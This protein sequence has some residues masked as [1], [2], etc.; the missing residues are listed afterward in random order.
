MMADDSKR[1]V[2]NSNLERLE[3]IAIEAK[4]IHC[5]IRVD[6]SDGHVV[7]SFI[8]Y[9]QGERL[10]VEAGYHFYYGPGYAGPIPALSEN[11]DREMSSIGQQSDLE[12][13]FWWEDSIGNSLK[14][15]VSDWEQATP[16]FDSIKIE[17]KESPLKGAEL[18]QL[19]LAVWMEAFGQE[20]PNSEG[21]QK[22]T[23]QARSK[24]KDLRQQC[25]EWLH[26]GSAGVK[27]WNNL[28]EDDR[29]GIGKL[30]RCQFANCDLREALFH[31]QDLRGSDFRQANLQATR[32]GGADCREA[33][34]RGADLSGAFLSGGKF[35]QADFSDARC[36][37]A[38]M[39][40]ADLRGA[41]FSRSNLSNV[42]FLFADL[43]HVD[44]SS[45]NLAGANFFRARYNEQTRFPDNFT[46]DSA[47]RMTWKGAVPREPGYV[48]NCSLEELLA[49]IPAPST[50]C[51]T[52]GDWEEAAT[53]IGTHFPSDF[54]SLIGKYGGGTILGGI[55]IYNPLTAEDREGI[56]GDLDTLEETRE[57]CQYLWRIHPEESGIL[58][59]GRDSNGNIYCWL[60]I[61]EPDDWPTGLIGHGEDEPSSDQVNITTFLYN[62]ARNMYPEMQGGLTFSESDYTFEPRQP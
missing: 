8:S 1:P 22:R 54:Q 23:K 26:S 31:N 39:R 29:I 48:K 7:L 28:K 16:D 42:D 20:A 15:M 58:P 30:G 61:G 52:S 4:Q 40:N 35:L 51:D 2:A 38:A 36:C 32:M 14:S 43:R 13:Y 53:A 50:P 34:F 11:P 60:T 3:A 57:G 62:F 59:W 27:K 56:A 6:V 45:A 19:L 47:W 55:D 25:L 9:G 41:I 37:N 24:K 21:L 49:L 5:S 18:E 33:L 17:T 10:Q 12:D 46:I 44:L